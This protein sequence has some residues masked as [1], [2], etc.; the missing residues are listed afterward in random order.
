MAGS[1]SPQ[2]HNAGAD[3]TPSISLRSMATVAELIRDVVSEKLGRSAVLKKVKNRC[4]SY[5]TDPVFSYIQAADRNRRKDYRLG[6]KWEPRFKRLWFYMV[7][8]PIG[9]GI[10]KRNLDVSELFEVIRK[11]AKFRTE[12]QLLYSSREEKRLNRNERKKVHNRSLTSFLDELKDFDDTIGLRKDLFP[13]L[14]NRGKSRTTERA[15]SAGNQ[16]GLLLASAAKTKFDKPTIKKIID[17]AWP[18]FMALYPTE[19]MF[20]REATLARQLLVKDEEKHCSFLSIQRL[21]RTIKVMECNGLIDAAHI[22][23]HSM[24][25]SDKAEN[26]IWLCRTH[27]KLTEGRLK[28]SWPRPEYL[29]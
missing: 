4:D 16:F 2:K 29:K 21:P 3:I 20:K 19:P 18:M 14:P 10:F 25:G 28:G 9:A 5:I 13:T 6:F 22:K 12:H 8:N 23:P 11:T 24:G 26:G 1:K 15:W 27:H 17:D 7:H